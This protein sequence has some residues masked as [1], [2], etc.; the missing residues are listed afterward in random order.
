MTFVLPPED[1]RALA[2]PLLARVAGLLAAQLAA[3]ATALAEEY[4][5]GYMD[6]D[7]A[8]KYL[9]IEVRALENWMKPLR[10]GGRGLPHLKVGATVRFRRCRIDAWAL[11]Q[12]VNAPPMELERAA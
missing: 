12:E 10:E 1:F 2:E 9:G 7:E 3:S 5:S 6:K 8:A 4:A 11:T